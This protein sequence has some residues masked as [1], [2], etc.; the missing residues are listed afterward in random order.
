VPLNLLASP[1]DPST[2]PEV[3]AEPVKE[4]CGRREPVKFP[5][6]EEAPVNE[7]VGVRE[8]A[9]NPAVEAEPTTEPVGV[10]EPAN[11]PDG[12]T[13]AE[14]DPVGLRLPETA[15][16]EATAPLIEPIGLRDPEMDPEEDTAP[17]EDPDDMCEPENDPE[18]EA[19][20][21]TVPEF[22]SI[23][24][25]MATMKPMPGV[26]L[27]DEGVH[28]RVPVAPAPRVSSPPAEPQLPGGASAS[29]RSAA[30]PGGVN[31][32]LEFLATPCIRSL[33]APVTVTE[34]MT[35]V[36]VPEKPET[37]ST[38]LAGS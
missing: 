6:T 22:G 10:R 8:P 34:G 27:P 35:K 18:D 11:N 4:P 7:P 29:Q 14:M 37:T 23:E 32:V 24:D 16:D 21:A 38:G 31:V 13:V 26:V 19:A 25:L 17:D 1:F 12:V 33:F 5:E 20:P 15:P 30:V 9:N 3:V 2:S 36:P 28:V